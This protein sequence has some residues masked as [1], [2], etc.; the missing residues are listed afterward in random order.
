MPATR[1][2]P[3]A[4]VWARASPR[5]SSAANH[6]N[7]ATGRVPLTLAGENRPVASLDQVVKEYRTDGQLI[8]AV[9]GVSLDVFPGAFVTLVGRSGCG[10]STLLNLA[11]A[12]DFPTTGQVRLDGVAT[13][14]RKSRIYFS[15]ISIASDA[16]CGRKRRASFVAGRQEQRARSCET[17]AGMGRTRILRRSPA[18]P[19][20]GRPNAACGHR[21]CAGTRSEIAARR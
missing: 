20:L 10:K 5:S 7:S 18:P 2:A 13:T 19:T 12:M 14:S 1:F 21:P 9:D 15:I 4:S 8:R 16:E 11:G 3:C 17:S 6:M